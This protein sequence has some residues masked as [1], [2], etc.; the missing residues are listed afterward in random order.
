M[1]YLAPGTVFIV[2]AGAHVDYGMPTGP[3]LISGFCDWAQDKPSRE[4][5]RAIQLVAPATMARQRPTIDV[6]E[7]GRAAREHLLARLK[8]L[9]RRLGRS[10]HGS[11]D[12]L[13]EQW[14]D[15]EMLGRQVTA[16]ILLI[17]EQQALSAV[18]VGGLYRWLANLARHDEPSMRNG[19][20]DAFS[21]V[22][23]VT[24]NYDRLAEQYLRHFLENHAAD[25]RDLRPPA[26]LHVYG[27]L[28]STL[29]NESATSRTELDNSSVLSSS[30]TIQIA[31]ARRAT[32][33]DED[34]AAIHEAIYSA[35]RLV[36]LGFDFH[37]ANLHRLGFSRKSDSLCDVF[38][39]G[40]KL[41][42]DKRRRAQEI[43][44]HHI[45]FGDK[46]HTCLPCLENWTERLCRLPVSR[47]DIRIHV[48]RLGGHGVEENW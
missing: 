40:Y 29:V 31:Q 45:E 46:D 42:T 48:P 1:A 39:T 22:S 32:K 6:P 18:H 5:S 11:I 15:L 2:G 14:P 24:F 23:I 3:Q 44:G 30:S 28:A 4:W 21:G 20:R 43:I 17:H 13:L 37:E 36:F 38:A 12:S 27:K 34:L 33:D 47:R 7:G 16:A 41:S 9:A 26:I 25:V 10:T 8:E 19:L 35:S